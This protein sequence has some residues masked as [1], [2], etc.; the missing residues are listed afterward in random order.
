MVLA[1]MLFWATLTLGFICLILAT[2]LLFIELKEEEKVEKSEQAAK[3]EHAE[4]QEQ[5]EQRI[6]LT[7]DEL[8]VY[9]YIK[10]KQEVLQSD[11]AK[12]LDIPKNRLAEIIKKLEEQGLI[13][14]EK[15]GRTYKLRA[16]Q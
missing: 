11:L 8:K 9:N 7:E 13:E 3:Q 16:K 1:D 6:E 4:Q 12:E 14:R 5:R 15:T 2:I 10:E